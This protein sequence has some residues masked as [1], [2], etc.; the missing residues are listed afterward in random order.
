MFRTTQP[1]TN[2]SPPHT[3][4]PLRPSS[5]LCSHYAGTSGAWDGRGCTCA[6]IPLGVSAECGPAAIAAAALGGLGYQ[7]TCLLL[8]GARL[9]P[10]LQLSFIP[11]QRRGE[12]PRRGHAK[13]PGGFY[14]WSPHCAAA[15]ANLAPS[16][17]LPHLAFPL[18][19]A[20][21][22]AGALEVRTGLFFPCC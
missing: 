3:G 7:L 8:P 21:W 16:A 1:D 19:L 15:S 18:L 10:P 12:A 14:S 17:M 6:R 13:P 20:F 9:V 11:Q 22:T 2:Q 4:E 5:N